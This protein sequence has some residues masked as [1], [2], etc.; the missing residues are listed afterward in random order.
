MGP[1]RWPLAVDTPGAR[2]GGLWRWGSHELDEVVW[3]LAEEGL[4]MG[5][6]HLWGYGTYRV[7]TE[8][9][10]QPGRWAMDGCSGHTCI[11]RLALPASQLR[12]ETSQH[13]EGSQAPGGR[14]A[15][16]LPVVGSS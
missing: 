13:Q 12:S 8:N 1:H 7:F 3:V 11:R 14:G 16:S 2:L 9:R 6:T 4:G 10:L 5:G 15:R